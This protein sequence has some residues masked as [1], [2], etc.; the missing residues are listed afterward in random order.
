MTPYLRATKARLW[1]PN[2]DLAASDERR[3]HNPDELVTLFS[4]DVWRFASAQMRRRED[5]EDVVMET[6]AA[7][8]RDF[9]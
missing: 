1:R 2:I 5:A 4:E 8:F 9:D 3:A 7:A 6:F